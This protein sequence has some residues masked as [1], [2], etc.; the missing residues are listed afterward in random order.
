MGTFTVW[1]RGG[2]GVGEGGGVKS[3]RVMQLEDT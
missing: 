2:K 1:E 3:V